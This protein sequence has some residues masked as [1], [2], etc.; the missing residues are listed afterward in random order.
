[1]KLSSR[2]LDYGNRR[3]KQE[4]YVFT[5]QSKDGHSAKMKRKDYEKKS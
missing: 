2:G 3:Q 1:M 4:S 5:M